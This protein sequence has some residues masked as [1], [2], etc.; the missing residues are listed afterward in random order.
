M[1]R[2]ELP[3]P[4]ETKLKN[5]KLLPS[6]ELLSA[7]LPIELT[8]GQEILIDYGTMALAYTAVDLEAEAGRLFVHE[9][10]PFGTKTVTLLRCTV[11]GT[12]IQQVL[13]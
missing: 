2:S 4:R 7:K 8:A 3:L 12:P 10:M 13:N 9:N 5:L 6:G 11:K 1:Y